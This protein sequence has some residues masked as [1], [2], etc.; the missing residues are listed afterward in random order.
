VKPGETYYGKGSYNRTTDRA[1]YD[2]EWIRIFGKDCK[3]CFGTGLVNGTA[4]HD[5][6]SNQYCKNCNGIGRVER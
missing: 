5:H 1:K 2:E 6:L 4:N 3:E